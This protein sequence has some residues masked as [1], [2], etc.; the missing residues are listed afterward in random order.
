MISCN[1]VICKTRV[2]AYQGGKE[3]FHSIKL[4]AHQK[5]LFFNLK[6]ILVNCSVEKPVGEIKVEP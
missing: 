3:F 6:N 1:E 5:F 2:F 4:T